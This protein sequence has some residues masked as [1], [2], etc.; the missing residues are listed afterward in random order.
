MIRLK[1]NLESISSSHPVQLLNNSLLSRKANKRWRAWVLKD[2]LLEYENRINHQPRNKGNSEGMVVK[3]A[4]TVSNTDSRLTVLFLEATSL[5]SLISQ[6][7]WSPNSQVP[8]FSFIIL[9]PLVEFLPQLCDG[10]QIGHMRVAAPLSLTL[11][12]PFSLL[13]AWA[14]VIVHVPTNP[15]LGLWARPLPEFHIP[16]STGHLRTQ[17]WCNKDILLLPA[18]PTAVN[19]TALHLVLQ[20]KLPRA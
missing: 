11:L 19:G 1:R 15:R 13:L 17:T 4:S 10:D 7:N 2:F 20:R 9:S 8:R 18:A 6:W 12:V 14:P 5:L 16:Y 3:Q